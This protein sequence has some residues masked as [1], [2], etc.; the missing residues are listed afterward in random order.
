MNFYLLISTFNRVE[1]AIQ[2][3]S[4]W[5]HSFLE[6][7]DDLQKI[8]SEQGWNKYVCISHIISNP[9]THVHHLDHV[10]LQTTG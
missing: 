8:K 6:E 1:K 10:N 2:E 7:E 9:M 5:G 3:S 4:L